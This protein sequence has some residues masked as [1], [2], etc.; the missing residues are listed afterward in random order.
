MNQLLIILI[1]IFS[2]TFLKAESPEAL[3]L[4][5]VPL[6]LQ[7]AN[8]IRDPFRKPQP[9]V[10]KDQ[11]TKKVPEIETLA[12]E[13]LRL[14]GV[15]TGPKKR[16]ALVTGPS[17]KMF[18]LTE[19]IRVGQR[20]GVIKRISENNVLVQERLTNLLGEEERYETT[21]E[22]AANKKKED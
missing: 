18:I 10:E 2:P 7:T 1:S 20:H 9:K 4:G 19:G 22:F 8:K 11:V 6:T 14:V 17:G 16:K 15:I 5:N 12:V 13:E 21:I 3:M